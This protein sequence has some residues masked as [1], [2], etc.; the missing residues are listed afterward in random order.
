MLMRSLLCVMQ[1]RDMEHET[2][3]A[4]AQYRT[5]MQSRIR[6][7]NADVAKFRQDLRAAESGGGRSG[8]SGYQNSRNEL[9]D[10]NEN[11]FNGRTVDQRSRLLD[12]DEILGRTSGRIANAQRIGQESEAIGEG[13]LSELHS[14]RETIVRTGNKV[15]GVDQNLSKSRAILNGMARRVMT[16]QMVMIGIIICLIG[17][18][19]IVILKK[20]G[21]L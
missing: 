7:Y 17:I 9:F 5:K 11:G 1:V 4:P 3:S 6:G 12:N 13:V 20:I 2:R 15:T 18:L 16:N 10:Q 19:I 8:G 14:Q 21:H